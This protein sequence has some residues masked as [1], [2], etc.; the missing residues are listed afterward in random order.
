[1]LVVLAKKLP[2]IGTF[3]CYSELVNQF[4]AVH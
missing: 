3:Y 4:S 2:F 1:L